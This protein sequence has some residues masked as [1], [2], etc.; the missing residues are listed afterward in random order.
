V[1]SCSLGGS[2][3]TAQPHGEVLEISGVCC[4]LG[5][6]RKTAQPH[7]EVLEI[8][9]VEVQ[10]SSAWERGHRLEISLGGFESWWA[11]RMCWRQQSLSTHWEGRRYG[12][13]HP[14]ERAQQREVDPP[15]CSSQNLLLARLGD[16]RQR[17]PPEEASWIPQLSK[18]QCC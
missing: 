5:G 3:K 6:W 12:S 10:K 1:L 7:G 15:A 2:R 11:Q 4:S 17:I 18:S 14:S 13:R 16:R 9:D 8:S